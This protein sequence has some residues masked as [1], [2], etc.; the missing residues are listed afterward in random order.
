MK[1]RIGN[2][3][4][5]GNELEINGIVE[6][7][8]FQWLPPRYAQYSVSL[9]YHFLRSYLNVMCPALLKNFLFFF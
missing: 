4:N 8:F 7:D 5:M 1:T 3:G 2:F 9:A 6:T